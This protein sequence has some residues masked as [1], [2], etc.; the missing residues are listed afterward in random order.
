MWKWILQNLHR[1]FLCLFA[2]FLVQPPHWIILSVGQIAEVCSSIKFVSVKLWKGK[3]SGLQL[4]HKMDWL[5]FSWLYEFSSVSLH[6]IWN[7]LKHLLQIYISVVCTYDFSTFSTFFNFLLTLET[8]FTRIIILFCLGCIIF[9][10]KAFYVKFRIALSTGHKPTC[11][12]Y[13]FA[14]LFAAQFYGIWG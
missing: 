2:I 6:F 8:Y 3:L 10:I 12:G 7:F 14:A 11:F 4:I 9:C 5:F 13:C 1:I